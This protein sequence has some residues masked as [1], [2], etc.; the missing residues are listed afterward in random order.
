MTEFLVGCLVAVRAMPSYYFVMMNM[1]SECIYAET[2]RNLFIG[3]TG[4][5]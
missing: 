4:P 1:V 3:P 2:T 5:C